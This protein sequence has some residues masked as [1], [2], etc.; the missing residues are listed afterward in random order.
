M[1]PTVLPGA[2]PVRPSVG[3]R[4]RASLAIQ[5]LGNKLNKSGRP[6]FVAEWAN[7]AKRSDFQ[8]ILSI[9]YDPIKSQQKSENIQ[10]KK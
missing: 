2:L 9:P 6:L 4:V 3:H 10:K 1:R 5:A 7:T 8:M